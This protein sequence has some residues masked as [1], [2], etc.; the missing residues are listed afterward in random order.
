[1]LRASFAWRFVTTQ[2][3]VLV[4]V[5]GLFASM[6]F[7][8]GYAYD[9][10]GELMSPYCPGRTLSSCPSPQAAELVQWISI[11]EAAGASQ[12]EVVEQLIERFGE[13]ILG[14]PPAEGITLWAY[15][16]PV[17][18]FLG[19]GGIAAVVLRRMVGRS[20]D[21]D[22][23]AP[24]DKQNSSVAGAAASPLN[25]SKPGATAGSDTDDELARLVDAEL[26]GRR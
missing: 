23:Q 6:S 13:E 11:Q 12:D 26:A 25:A 15:I 17:A 1:M 16:F 22:S 14:S 2:A 9:L 20:D 18:G 4:L 8:E 7:A 10:A 19:G 5:L 24:P 21:D 3:A